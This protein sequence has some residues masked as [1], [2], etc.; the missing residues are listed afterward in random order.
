MTPYA[1]AASKRIAHVQSHLEGGYAVDHLLRNTGK[2]ACVTSLASHAQASAM[3]AWFAHR[4]L[5]AMRQWCY[6]AA[7]LTRKKYLMEDDGAGPG[8]KTLRLLDP[9]LSNNEALIDWF[10]HQDRTYDLR[11][12]EDHKTHDFWA[13]Q[14]LLALRGD[15]DR[16]IERCERVIA[17]PPDAS[18]EQRYQI[19]HL[20]YLALARRDVGRMQAVLARI[21]T[22]KAVQARS[23][24]DSGYAIG[25]I[26]TIGVIYAKIA[27]RHGC[28][29]QVNSPYIP[30][31][32]LPVE[33]L[34]HYDEH[35]DFLREGRRWKGSFF[36]WLFRPPTQ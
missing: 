4:D 1:E 28:R 30:A 26:S 34:A 32:W 36:H 21:V 15:W 27:W 22:P 17:D 19:D 29:V 33:P 18:V 9:L 11:R 13:Y 24:D 16:L 3:H 10:A 7:R 5:E 12:A 25:L 23:N 8:E 6:V 31:E 14:A 20:F 35:Y 2:P